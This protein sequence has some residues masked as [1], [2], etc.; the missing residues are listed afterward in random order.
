MAAH[1]YR[2][3]RLILLKRGVLQE[4]LLQKNGEQ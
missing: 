4:A 1:R 3:W 2:N